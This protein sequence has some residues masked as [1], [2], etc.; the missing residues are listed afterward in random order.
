M[1]DFSNGEF[2][3][4]L[5][6]RA[7]RLRP[8]AGRG[9]IERAGTLDGLLD[10]GAVEQRV[11]ARLTKALVPK[12]DYPSFQ[13]YTTATGT[14]VRRGAKKAP[15]RLLTRRGFLRVEVGRLE[16]PSKASEEQASTSI[17][18]NLNVPVPA[19]TDRLSHR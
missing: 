15:P 4:F 13:T 3:D 6:V 10:E 16:L 17:F 8:A 2:D 1:A 19:P 12:G 14:G 5:R 11:D 7:E 9:L 18:R